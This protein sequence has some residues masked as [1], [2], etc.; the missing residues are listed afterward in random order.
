C[1]QGNKHPSSF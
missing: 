1:Q